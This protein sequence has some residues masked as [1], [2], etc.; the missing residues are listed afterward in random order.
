MPRT[1]CTPGQP[2][3]LAGQAGGDLV[4]HVLRALARPLGPDDHLVV[5][6]VRDGIDRHLPPRPEPGDGEGRRERERQEGITDEEGEHPNGRAGGRHPAEGRT[7]RR[8]RS[9]LMAPGRGESAGG[10]EQARGAGEL[11]LA[12]DQEHALGGDF[13]PGSRSGAHDKEVVAGFV[14]EPRAEGERREFETQPTVRLALGHPPG[15][16]AH[17]R[18]ETAVFGTRANVPHV[19][20]P[21][22]RPPSNRN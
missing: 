14:L 21:P 4:V 6:Q 18:G 16:I 15:H 3:Q 9:V 22:G 7:C 13:V 11:G 1:V 17:A 20:G 10:K 5:A 12:V 19:L 8:K 2:L